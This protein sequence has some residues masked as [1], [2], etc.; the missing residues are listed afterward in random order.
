MSDLFIGSAVLRGEDPRLL[1]G[2]GRYISDV[3]AP[4]M[5]HAVVIRS[6]H[7]HARIKSVAVGKALAHPGVVAVYTADDLGSAQMN[8]PSFGQFPKQLMSEL[9][10]MIREAAVTTLASGKVR[11]V[12]EPVALLVAE[13]PY[14]AADAAELVDIDYEPL[15]V[16]AD[17]HA[18]NARVFDDWPDNVALEMVV[19]KGDA[20]AIVNSSP[21]VIAETFYSHRYT[22]VP[23]EGRGCLAI[24][25][26]GGQGLMIWTAHQMPHFNRSLVCEALKLPS[27]AVRV[28][29]PDIGGAFGQKAGLYPEDVLIPFAAHKL[30]RPVKWLEDKNE[31]FMASSHSREQT[32]EA[33]L[34]LTED[35]VITA[36]N[37]S[38][39][40]DAGA[41]LTFP[42]VIPHLGFCH[43]L[44]P[45]RIPA[46]RA[47]IRSILTNKV[48]SAP[49]RGAGRP[50][51]VFMLN[52]L[53]DL[54]AEKLDLDPAEIRRRNF[55]QP[56]E[57]PFALDL[58]YRDGSPMVLDSG[59]YPKALEMTLDAIGYDRFREEQREARKQGRYIG[60]GIA[61]N[62]ESGGIGPVESAR[63]EIATDG[64]IGVFVGITDTGQGSKT[65]LAQV[66]AAVLKVEPGQIR[67]STGDTAG[68]QFS[69]GTYHSRAAVTAGNAVNMAAIAVREKA[70]KLAAHHLEA[71]V[72][73]LEIDGGD[74][75]VV[76][77]PGMKV[78]LAECA[79]LALPEASRP[80]GVTPGINETSYF[81]APQVVWGNA[82][83]VATVEV[84][85]NTGVFKVLRYVVLH[86]CGTVLNPIIL[87]GQVHGGIA[88]G[89]GGTRLE[90]LKYNEEGQLL[91]ATLADYMLP[92]A[93]DMPNIEL[94]HLETPS[95]VN[96]L[97][98]K[99]GGEGGTIAP[100]AVFAAA[101]EDALRP[102]G[103][104][105]T[106][107]PLTAP[108]ILAAIRNAKVKA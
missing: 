66:C 12:G 11:Y 14:V 48:T 9:R 51:A 70:F 1:T 62:I 99:G 2:K 104:R 65:S 28:A 69:R 54:A 75:R 52:R 90:Q 73:D 13:D 43:L 88:A 61:C 46:I 55:I 91:T 93:S 80:P 29:Q 64:S 87:E 17:V 58:P 72:E 41:Y 68:L 16:A 77:V 32:F 49:Y 67:V 76:G 31:H 5:L 60:I 85:T 18:T 63:V 4:G 105:I 50:E 10:P 83:H 19:G 42:V 35:G 102:F 44:G 53:M 40:V 81:D 57:M 106:E 103:V 82:S 7:A 107:T 27:F 79:K 8:L 59:D 38:V 33:K 45:Y 101:V 108:K 6:V 56:H 47:H 3:A 36:L 23:L 94:L 84:D 24:P 89:I 22:G 26:A 21:H 98:V 25:D 95:P 97:G 96:P 34:G 15:P 37:Y 78:S 30:Q 100:P 39:V 86:D 74:I 20:E 71:S 92:R